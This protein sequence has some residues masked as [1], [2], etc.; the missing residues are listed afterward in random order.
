MLDSTSIFLLQL[1][2]PLETVHSTLVLAR[3]RG[4]ITI[5][6]PAPA[7]RLSPPLLSQVDYLT[8]NQS[9]AAFLLGA[10]VEP[11]SVDEAQ[12]AARN[13][14]ALGPSNVILKLGAL[15]VVIAS[16]GGC[17]H[18]PGFAVN[19]IDTTAAGDTFNGAFA[20]AI[21]NQV[22]VLDAAR[23]ANAAAALSVTRHG[24][25]SSIPDR[26]ETDLFLSRTP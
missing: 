3:Q 26:P 8:P 5:L 14:L 22:P 23:F 6:D 2:I 11:R 17:T 25:Q 10:E 4:A 15:G 9:E 7:A 20:A 19:A 24:A 21:S 13:L 16:R 12:T 1:E 18:V